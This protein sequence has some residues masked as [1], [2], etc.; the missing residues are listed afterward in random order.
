VASSGASC[1]PKAEE[2]YCDP[3]IAKAVSFSPRLDGGER[4]FFFIL[5]G[6]ASERFVDDFVGKEMTPMK[7]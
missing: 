2:H 4:G 6:S 7:R 5:R 3:A 1:Q